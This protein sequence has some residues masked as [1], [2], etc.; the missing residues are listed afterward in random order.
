MKR[1]NSFQP[2]RAGIWMILRGSL[3]AAFALPFVVPMVQA[4][5]PQNLSAV[6]DG[7]KFESD[8]DGILYL[9]PTKSKL[10]L[11]AGT[12]GGSA[13]PPPKALSDKLSIMCSNF[14]NKPRK[15]AAK[16]FGSHGC[17]VKF[18]KGESRKPFGD[19]VAEY[20]VV[21]SA[22]NAFEITSV[23]GKVIEGKFS[24]EMVDIKSKAK[25]K[26]TDGVFKAEDRQQ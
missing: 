2:K 20:K 23:K 10:N 11:I 21:D 15:Y 5:T 18:I 3:A 9:M 22:S 26:I 7:R 19:P 25:L 17:E 16:D 8:D 24:F 1:V 14:D 4:A 13:Y 12:K 6:I